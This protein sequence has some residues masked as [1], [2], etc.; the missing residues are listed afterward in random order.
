MLLTDNGAILTGPF[1]AGDW[2]TLEVTLHARGVVLSDSR[3][4]HPADLWQGERFYQTQKEWLAS[5]PR[6]GSI[7]QLQDQLDQFRD[8]YNHLR[9]HRTLGRSPPAKAVTIQPGAGIQT[10][11]LVS[12]V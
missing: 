5:Q 3:P 12:S 1:C 4:Y 11:P 8:Y 7:G 6:A 10:F 9:P 2:V